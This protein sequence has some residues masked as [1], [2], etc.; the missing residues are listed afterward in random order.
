MIDRGPNS[1]TLW[2]VKLLHKTCCGFQKEVD[3][4][5]TSYVMKKEKHYIM[6]NKYI[7]KFW[8][9]ISHKL[10]IHDVCFNPIGQIFMILVILIIMTISN[11]MINLII[12]IFFKILIILILLK[13]LTIL[14]IDIFFKFGHFDNDN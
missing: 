13:M 2:F 6:I 12:L 11:I 10:F 4:L 3:Y 5:Y 1:C 14:I 7:A 9:I 8:L